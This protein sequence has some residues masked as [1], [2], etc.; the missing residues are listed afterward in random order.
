MSVSKNTLRLFC[1][2]LAVVP[3]IFSPRPCAAQE[4]ASSFAQGSLAVGLG[5]SGSGASTGPS[6]GGNPGVMEAYV[7]LYG[8]DSA[9]M[10]GSS[11]DAERAWRLRGNSRGDLLW[12]QNA[13][14]DYVVRDPATL[15]TALEILSSSE[16]GAPE[17][18][19]K[20]RSFLTRTI[21]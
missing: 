2:C 17:A 9:F 6:A 4:A 14:R 20:F 10:S 15:K 11:A 7:L 8:P 21:K 13:G 18:D 19:K 3:A 12:F 1:C 16:R 5:P